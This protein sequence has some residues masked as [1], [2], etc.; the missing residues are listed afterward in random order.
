MPGYVAMTRH[1]TNAG[2]FYAFIARGLGRPLGV[3]A[4]LVALLAYSF[5]QVGLYGAFGPAAQAEAQ[6]HLH[7]SAPWWAWA[8][9]SWARQSRS[10][11]CCASTSPAR[12]SAS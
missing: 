10:W 8:L 1:I 4:A 9:A 2:A 12:S 3:A 5:L 7:L 11:A 6:A